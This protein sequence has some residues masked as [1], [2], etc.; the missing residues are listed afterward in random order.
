MSREE[1]YYIDKQLTAAIN[2]IHV[3]AGGY[4][5][6]HYPLVRDALIPHKK[7]ANEIIEMKDV[8]SYVLHHAT[9]LLTRLKTLDDIYN[10]RI[11]KP[12]D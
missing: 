9:E 6:E 11:P 5:L 7:L 12:E 2:L 3:L 10:N 8:D 4:S 1:V